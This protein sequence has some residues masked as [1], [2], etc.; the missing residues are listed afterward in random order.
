MEQEAPQ[1]MSVGAGTAPPRHELTHV[2][3]QT[4]CGVC[5]RTKSRDDV[6]HRRETLGIAVSPVDELVVVEA[7]YVTMGQATILAWYCVE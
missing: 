1:P 3:F 4:W 5:V 6:H 7:D 2:P